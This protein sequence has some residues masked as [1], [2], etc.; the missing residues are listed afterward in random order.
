M[1]SLLAAPESTAV[2]AS[3]AIFGLMGYTLHYRLRRLP[4]RYMR[5]DTDLLQIIGLNLVIGFL[6][7]RI[8]QVAHL[9]GLAGGFIAASLV[10]MPARGHEVKRAWP[11]TIIAGALVAMTTY[12][13]TQPLAL[14]SRLQPVAPVVSQWLDT[15]YGRY[16]SFLWADGITLLWKPAQIKSEWS[17]AADTLRL[18]SGQLAQLAIFWQWVKGAGATRSV[19]YIITWDKARDDG[20][21]ERIQEDR[22]LA[23]NPDDDRTKI[24]L[25]ST[26]TVGAGSYTVRVNVDGREVWRAAVRIAAAS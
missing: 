9:G 23:L 20:A 22:R 16:F 11:E 26:I 25:R 12:V 5:I 7:P 21:Y 17:P 13:A 6:L 24:Y 8:D 19:S 14:A 10:G 18:Q 15:R 2:G 4:L 1:L 3:A